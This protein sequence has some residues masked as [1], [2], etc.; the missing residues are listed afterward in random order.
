[1]K[2]VVNSIRLIQLHD[3]QEDSPGDCLIFAEAELEAGGMIYTIKSG[4]TLAPLAGDHTEIYRHEFHLLIELLQS[5][6]IDWS[7]AEL[8]L[9]VVYRNYT[10]CEYCGEHASSEINTLAWFKDAVKSD[11]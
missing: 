9:P 5:W 10:Y 3:P 4:G 6:Q 2:T 7:T 1:M 8:P 11:G